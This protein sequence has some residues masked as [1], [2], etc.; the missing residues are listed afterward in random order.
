MTLAKKMAVIVSW[1][2]AAVG[3]G[4]A[5][6][7]VLSAYM[8]TTGYLQRDNFYAAL[9]L[10][11]VAILLALVVQL[12][13]RSQQSARVWLWCLPVYFVAGGPV[14]FLVVVWL[15]QHTR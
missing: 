3:G 15:D 2:F 13:L 7:T 1:L 10:P 11:L 14:L 5:M 4:W 8:T 12:S 9:P 6:L